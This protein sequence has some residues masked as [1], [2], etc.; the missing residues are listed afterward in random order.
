MCI[1]DRLG[2]GK[3]QE[4]LA[5]FASQSGYSIDKREIATKCFADSVERF[6]TLLTTDQIQQ[7]YDRYN[8]SESDSKE[9]QKLMGQMLDA[10]EKRAQANKK[11][12]S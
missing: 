3:S 10:I 8:A 5:N 1:R 2:T 11:S 6:G 7:Q 9:V 4:A 12:N